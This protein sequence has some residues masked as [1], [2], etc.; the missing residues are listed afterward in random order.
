M[1]INEIFDLAVEADHN[2]F[3]TTDK[4][5]YCAVMDAKEAWEKGLDSRLQHEKKFSR[6]L[7]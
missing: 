6:V 7:W 5:I 2:I 3:D 4:D 1:D